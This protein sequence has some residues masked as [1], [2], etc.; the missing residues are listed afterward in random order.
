M[1]IRVMKEVDDLD[2][3]AEIDEI[4]K[5][6]DAIIQNIEHLDPNKQ[7]SGESQN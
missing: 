6:I 3:K 1:E 7:E 4:A 5:K 2:I